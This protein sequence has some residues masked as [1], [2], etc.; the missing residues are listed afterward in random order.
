MW[1][2][3]V[4]FKS[5]LKL[6]NEL[7]CSFQR[8]MITFILNI[9][10]NLDF[11]LYTWKL[12]SSLNFYWCIFLYNLHCFLDPATNQ[13]PK[14][15]QLL[16]PTKGNNNCHCT[17]KT[18]P[19]FSWTARSLRHAAECK[20]RQSFIKCCSMKFPVPGLPSSQSHTP[21]P[22]LPLS[23]LCFPMVALYYKITMDD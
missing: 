8:F 11:T 15:Y 19:S 7:L 9:F 5:T 21:D 1:H 12:Y 17:V 22:F 14:A 13:E 2:L 20:D 10:V 23:P 4:Y 18:I 6:R 16:L 3:H